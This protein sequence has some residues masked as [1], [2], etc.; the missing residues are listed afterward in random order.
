MEKEKM[1]YYTNSTG[2]EMTNIDIKLNIDYKSKDKIIN[3]CD[4]VFSPEQ[5]KLTSIMLNKAINEY[6][7][8][9]RKININVEEIRENEG[10]QTD[11]G[12]K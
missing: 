2:V 6:E 1:I 11:G 3:L 5:A 4:I 10:K 7:K 8:R 12:E 9:N